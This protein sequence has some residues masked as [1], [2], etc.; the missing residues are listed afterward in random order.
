MQA[1]Q[2]VGTDRSKVDTVVPRRINPIFGDFGRIVV[3]VNVDATEIAVIRF[4]SVGQASVGTDVIAIEQRV[5][6]G[7]GLRR[8]GRR[9]VA[10]IGLHM[11]SA[12][13]MVFGQ[14]E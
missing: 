11:Q 2:Q 6:V 8:V 12:E 3:G 9:P 10:L 7:D 13:S 14:L 4:E 5:A 1:H